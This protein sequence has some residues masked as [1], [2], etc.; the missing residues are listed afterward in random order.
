[1]SSSVICIGELLIDFFCTDVNIDL[2][3]GQSFEKQAGGAP[4]NVCATIVKLGGNAKFCGKVGNDPFGHFLKKTL[5]DLNVDTSMIVLDKEH[6]TTLAFVSLKADGERDFVFNRG[7][8]AFL[9]E[10]ELDKKKLEESNILHF[11]SAT[12][13][14]ED[15]FQSTYL[16]AMRTAKEADKFISFDPNFRKD[17][18]PDR[19]QTFIDLA[20]EGIA[21]ADFVKVSDD[22]LR[23]ITGMNDIKQG[24]LSLHNLGAKVIAVTLGKEG[25]FISNGENTEIVPSIKVNSIDSTGAGDAFVGATLFQLAKAGDPKNTLEDFEHL[26]QVITFS[27]RV[28]AMVCMK[29]GAIAAIPNIE[30]VS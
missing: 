13:L 5:D 27:N 21:L 7:A 22:E 10:D 8:D 20:K 14:L 1:M 6:P 3:D 11:G 30:E 19:I 18:W 17:L 29:V 9:S 24:I 23:I 16:N 2:V 4:A 12:A 15:P 25:T 26:K 28:G